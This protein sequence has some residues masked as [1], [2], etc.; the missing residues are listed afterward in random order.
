M[1]RRTGPPPKPTE[2]KLLEG[3]AGRRPLRGKAVGAI[4]VDIPPVPE[5]LGTAGREAWALYW[6]HGRAWLAMT[7]IPIL[8]QLCEAHDEAD[9][10]AAMIREEGL[11]HLNDK[12]GRSFTH[13]AYNDLRGLRREIREL[14]SLCYMTPTDR[15]RASVKPADEDPLAQWAQG[16]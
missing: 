13:H 9:R 3:N 1:S 5:Q 8:T 15:G 4:P 10:L 2:L 12:T 14:W 11:T 6:T 7:D 16:Q